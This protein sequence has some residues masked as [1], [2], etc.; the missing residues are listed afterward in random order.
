ML[1]ICHIKQIGYEGLWHCFNQLHT[2]NA[3]KSHVIVVQLVHFTSFQ[4]KNQFKVMIIFRV[5]KHMSPETT[6]LPVQ[7]LQG[8][9]ELGGFSPLVPGRLSLTLQSNDTNDNSSKPLPV[10]T[11]FFAH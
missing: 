9:H 6:R 2:S 4:C 3:S 5:K 11:W 7:N 8:P 1:P 10:T